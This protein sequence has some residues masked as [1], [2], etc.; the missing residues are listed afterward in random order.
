MT[1]LGDAEALV[2]GDTDQLKQVLLNLVVNAEHALRRAA[3]RRLLVTLE[4]HGALR[5]VVVE[6]SGPGVPEELRGRIFEPFFTTKP[7]GEGSGLGLSVSYGIVKEHGG[8]LWHEQPAGG[9]ARFVIEL[10]ACREAALGAASLPATPA[11]ALRTGAPQRVLLVEDE[12]ALR[13]IG[14]RVL[15]RVGHA[16]DVAADG[17]A[18]LALLEAGSYDVVLCDV[19]M[20]NLTGPE[21]FAEL[22]RRGALRRMRFVATTGDIA[23][24]DTQAFPERSGVPVLLKPFQLTGLLEAVAA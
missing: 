16:V 19:R 9:G 7:E 3:T 12:E 5:R 15:R 2:F 4:E 20:P 1:A 8:E 14:Q 6:D 13:S 24:P 18:A 21:L 22:E 23:D 11:A 10:P 17:H